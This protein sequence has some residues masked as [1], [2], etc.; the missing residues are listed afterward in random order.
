MTRG[1]ADLRWRKD[2]VTFGDTKMSQSLE[3]GLIMMRQ[4]TATR[5][6]LGISDLAD[7]LD[8]SRSTVYRYVTTLVALGFLEQLPNRKY[9]LGTRS[10]DIGQSVLDINGLPR[11]AQPFLK[12]LRERVGFTVSLA[13]LDGRDIVYG[14]R[15]YSHRKGQYQADEGRR[16]GSRALASCTAMGKA[17]LAGLPD[18]DSKEWV[19]LTELTPSTEN[20]IVRKSLFRADLE[21]VRRRGFA[22]SNRE[23]VPSLVALAAEVPHGATVS[24]A[25]GI[26][27]NA[28][29]ISATALANTCGNELLAT[30][31][32]LAEHFVGHA[33]RNG[34]S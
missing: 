28:G 5:P 19:E 34:N 20:S 4:F 11:M 14:A 17:L 12:D 7:N 2:L 15:A 13:L 10:S 9:T 24:A 18:E 6:A 8:M 23:L 27:A 30:A 31:S 21:E 32:D 16:V 26:A 1:I 25:V 33:R 29:V 22:I 3:I